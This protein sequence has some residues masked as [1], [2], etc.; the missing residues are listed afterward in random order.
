[1]PPQILGGPE[2]ETISLQHRN[3]PDVPCV[4]IAAVSETTFA[5]PEA[6]IRHSVCSS[7]VVPK[8]VL[9]IPSREMKLALASWSV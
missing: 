7:C 8:L 3:I 2:Q 5:F 1:M 4:D 6:V 9:A